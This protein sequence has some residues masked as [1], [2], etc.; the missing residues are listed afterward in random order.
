MPVRPGPVAVFVIH[1]LK[2]V[3]WHP[4]LALADGFAGLVSGG[5]NPLKFGDGKWRC[6]L[7]IESG[8]H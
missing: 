4:N 7:A 8:G 3:L 2:E 5:L 1:Q 6:E